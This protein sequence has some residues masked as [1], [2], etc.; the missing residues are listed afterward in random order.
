MTKLFGSL[1]CTDI[2][3]TSVAPASVWLSIAGLT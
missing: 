2:S 3:L 1:L